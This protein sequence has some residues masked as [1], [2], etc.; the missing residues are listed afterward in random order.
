M[1]QPGILIIGSRED[2]SPQR[3]KA[4]SNR[5]RREKAAT[6]GLFSLGAG[7]RGD[8]PVTETCA[9]TLTQSRNAD[10]RSPGRSSPGCPTPGSFFPDRFFPL[11]ALLAA[12]TA[13]S[14]I[15]PAACT[16]KTT[17]RATNAGASHLIAP[18]IFKG[19]RTRQSW[20]TERKR[21]PAPD[22][23]RGGPVSGLP[24]LQPDRFLFSE[25]PSAVH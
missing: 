22:P 24:P 10:R 25:T 7:K 11:S 2:F 1:A 20:L 5:T 13:V 19:Y 4:K 17:T 23:L 8:S 21:S 6:C 14:A 12:E 9:N 16:T 15:N 18:A 3:F